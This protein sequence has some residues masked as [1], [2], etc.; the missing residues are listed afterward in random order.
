M[1][2]S[3]WRNPKI[4]AVLLLV[5]L[6]GSAAGALGFRYVN[7]AATKS[8]PSWKEGGREISLQKIRGELDLT[9]EQAK[10]VEIV[11]D[12][13]MMYYQTLQAQMDEVRANGRERI[14]KILKPEQQEKFGR[15]L[16]DLQRQIR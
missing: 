10:E 16:S 7:R 6:T 11:L 4:L 13:F 1:A 2:Q 14:L 9:T 12:D 15:M 3:P 8:G 5:F